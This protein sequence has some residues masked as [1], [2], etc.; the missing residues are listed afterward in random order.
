MRLWAGLQGEASVALRPVLLFHFT[1]G[2]PGARQGPPPAT[3]TH[4]QG[5]R[6]GLTA[7][8]PVRDPPAALRGLLAQNPPLADVAT[9]RCAL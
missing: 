3:D 8:H 6:R 5:W 2:V 1:Y 4:S 7:L 9:Q